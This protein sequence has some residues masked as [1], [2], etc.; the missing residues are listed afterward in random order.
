MESMLEKQSRS[1]EATYGMLVPNDWNCQS[2]FQKL[3]GECSE[4]SCVACFASSKWIE[5]KPATANPRVGN[6]PTEA[7]AVAVESFQSLCAGYHLKHPNTI[8]C[9]LS[10]GPEK[11]CS[12]SRCNVKCS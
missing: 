6:T 11:G 4:E 3:C 12:T 10:F 7:P 5:T 9:E 8:Y 2:N 1:F